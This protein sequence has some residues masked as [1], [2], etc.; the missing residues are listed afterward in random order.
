MANGTSESKTGGSHIPNA[1]SGFRL[2]AAPVMLYLAWIGKPFSFLVLLAISLSTDAVD[3]Y[4]ARRLSWQSELGA[5]LDS[6]GDFATYVTVPL[7][8]WWLWPDVLRREAIFVWIAIAAYIVPLV[9]GFAKFRRLTSYHTWAAKVSAVVMGISALLLF[10]TDIAWPFRVAAVFQALEALEEIAITFTLPKRQS[11]IPSFWHARR[12][13]TAAPAG[14]EGIE[15]RI[16]QIMARWKNVSSKKMF[17]GIC[18]LL[19][20]NMVCG[21][22]REFLILRLGEKEAAAAL[23]KAHVKPFDITGK[24]MKGWV[25]VSE[26]GIAREADLKSWLQKAKKFVNTLPAK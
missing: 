6:W 14:G 12:E 4:L 23:E 1:L 26:E 13:I 25:M 7:G 8:A 3:G 16:N 15:K 10:L 2:L 18:C 11:N 22:Y 20:G 9:V 19:N 5:K 17:G 21:V 24:P